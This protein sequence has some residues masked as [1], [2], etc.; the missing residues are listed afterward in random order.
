MQEELTT[1]C[2]STKSTPGRFSPHR[3]CC[4]TSS[5]DFIPYLNQCRRPAQ[6]GY[7][8]HTCQAAL[9][10]SSAVASPFPSLQPVQHVMFHFT[11]LPRRV[12]EARCDHVD[13]LAAPSLSL[14]PLPLP[15]PTSL[16][17]FLPSASI[18]T[19][20]A[21]SKSSSSPT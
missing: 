15:P 12:V 11:S 20:P 5:I 7:T 21:S 16:L 8:P 3:A 6:A 13:F 18:T 19:A 4:C 1:C 9:Y 17:S 10:M 2:T 14:P